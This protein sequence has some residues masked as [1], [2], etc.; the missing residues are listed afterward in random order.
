M[1]SKRVVV[2]RHAV[3]QRILLSVLNAKLLQIR[4]GLGH[5]W[6]GNPP[7][8]LADVKLPR[9][10]DYERAPLVSFNT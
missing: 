7:E 10:V 9:I 3:E 8:K 5:L 2:G 6:I 1:R 4:C